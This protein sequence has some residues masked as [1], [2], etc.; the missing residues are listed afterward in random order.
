[1]GLTVSLRRLLASVFL[2]NVLFL[3]VTVWGQSGSASTIP[4]YRAGLKSIVIPAPTADLVET[5]SDYRVLLEPLAP[6][7]NRLIAAF[8]QSD[9]LAVIHSAGN[10]LLNRYALVEVPRR[11]EF[12]DV[13]PEIFKQITD[14]MGQ[15]FGAA[16]AASLKDQQDEINRR[17]KA[18]ETTPAEVTLEK[19]VQ[20][21]VLFCKPNACAF[22]M[23]MPVT[24]KGTTTKMMAGILVLRVQHR[25]IFIYTYNRFENSDSVKWVSTTEEQWSDAILKSNAQ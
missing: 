10:A 1:M 15:Q 6:I 21:G 12:S 24:A 14:G 25:V 19:P 13:S 20:L 16:V 17:L 8:V 18:L 22:G 23:I 4:T 9:D 2:T 11:A 3:P 7:N 5:G